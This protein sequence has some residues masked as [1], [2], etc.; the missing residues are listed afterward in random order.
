[1]SKS[2]L[3]V[4]KREDILIKIEKGL[5]KTSHDFFSVFGVI[6]PPPGCNATDILTKP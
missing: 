4:N 1:M 5:K 6:S 3:T 2:H